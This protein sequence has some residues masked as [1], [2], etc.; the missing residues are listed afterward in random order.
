MTTPHTTAIRVHDLSRDVAANL[1]NA[2]APAPHYADRVARLVFMT[3]AHESDGFNA[4]RHVGARTPMFTR[5]SWL[6]QPAPLTAEDINAYVLAHGHSMFAGIG[7][8][9]V[10]AAEKYGI[11]AAYILAHAA[12]ESAWGTSRIARDKRNL[13][14]WRAYDASPHASAS[15]F[16][17][18]AACI[19]YVMS[20]VKRDY[21]TPGGRYYNGEILGH[22]A[23]GMNVCYATDPDWGKKIAAIAQDI[24]RSCYRPTT[25]GLC[26]CDIDALS[27]ALQWIDATR[28]APLL[29]R[30]YRFLATHKIG[31]N[32]IVENRDQIL[33]VLQTPEGD[34][35]SVLLCR[36]RYLVVPSPVPQ[37]PLEM[38]GY[39]KRYYNTGAGK[40]TAKHYLDAYAEWWPLAGGDA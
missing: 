25:Y 37:H 22:K 32:L 23:A 30:A 3:I 17:S 10:T 16:P 5:E 11:N 7:E 31:I 28:R 14:G 33:Q 35:L 40:A 1:Y 20:R 6:T 13:F 15:E 29:S 18:F 19:D 38:A 24:L 8:A 36:L 34:P 2:T 12:H 26:H 9:I 27:K 39:A 4:R 21:L